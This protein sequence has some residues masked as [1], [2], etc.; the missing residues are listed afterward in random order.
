MLQL[1]RKG[2]FENAGGVVD[3]FLDIQFGQYL[4]GRTDR[5]LPGVVGMI[6]LI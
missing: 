6:A 4:D 3:A 5:M 2:R 1:V